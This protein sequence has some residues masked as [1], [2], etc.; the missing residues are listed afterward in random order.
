MESKGSNMSRH[1]TARVGEY[2]CPFQFTVRWDKRGYYIPLTK[3]SGGGVHKFHPSIDPSTLTIPTQ[4][5]AKNEKDTLFHLA[6][7]CCGN[8]VSCNYVFSKVGKFLSASKIAYLFDRENTSKDKNLQT[9]YDQLLNYFEKTDDIAYTVLWDVP[10]S[11]LPTSHPTT[12]LASITQ[13]NIST[14][15][16]LFSH[17]KLDPKNS[18]ETDLTNKPGMDNVHALVQLDCLEQNVNEDHKVFVAVAWV[19][20]KELWWFKMFP[21]VVHVDETSHSTEKSIIC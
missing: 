20:K 13:N 2:T 10:N 9:D 1:C 6:K 12:P 11:Q 17:T 14:P 21:E 15:S 5:L 7:S 3:N 18:S 16:R 4:F 19:V 8:G